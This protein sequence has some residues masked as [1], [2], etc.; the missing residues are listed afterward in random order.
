M[1][2]LLAFADT[3]T[4]S[5]DPGAPGDEVIWELALI[6]RDLDTPTEPDRSYLWQFYV[7][8]GKAN[9]RSLDIGGWNERRWSESDSKTQ[10]DSATDGGHDPEYGWGLDGEGW[11]VPPWRMN[12]WAAHFSRLT[13]GAHLIGAVPNFD[14]RRLDDL[15]RGNGACP[16]W[17]YH[18]ADVENIAVGWAAGQLAPPSAMASKRREQLRRI[19]NPPWSSDELSSAVGVNRSSFEEHTA[20]GDTMWVRALW[21]A[22]I[23]APAPPEGPF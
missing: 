9:A 11:L 5:L 1:T 18:L 14:D 3:E 21:D 16:A 8:A 13:W 23:P 15:L 7:D 22:M 2:N 4:I 17:H 12:E 19:V 6:L 20:M 10:E